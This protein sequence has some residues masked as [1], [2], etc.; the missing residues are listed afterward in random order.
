MSLQASLAPNLRH[1]LTRVSAYLAFVLLVIQRG[2]QWRTSV[3]VIAFLIMFVVQHESE[4]LL[5]RVLA[6]LL[7]GWIS[8]EQARQPQTPSE[9]T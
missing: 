4:G 8:F 3:L 1:D 5:A 2:P 6:L 9:Q 7:A